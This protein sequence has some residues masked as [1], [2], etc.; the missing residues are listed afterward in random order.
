[1]STTASREN[2][3]DWCLE[4]SDDEK[5]DDPSVTDIIQLYN[6]LRDNNGILQF[7]WI[8]PGRVLP[9]DA[10]TITD[11]TDNNDDDSDE[12]NEKNGADDEIPTEFDFDSFSSEPS[13]IT[14]RR[15]PATSK[16]PRTQK[17]VATMDKILGDIYRKRKEET[18]KSKATLFESTPSST[19]VFSGLPES[20]PSS[21]HRF[22]GLPESTSSTSPLIPGLPESNNTEC[23]L[24]HAESSSHVLQGLPEST[25]SPRIFPGLPEST[26]SSRIFPL[27]PYPG[28]PSESTSS[29]QEIDD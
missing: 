10:E 29:K 27:V 24:G 21:A 28:S 26:A 22:Q 1:M 8:N 20:T 14:P 5:D 6:K 16:T 15:T 4:A 7:N 19:N 11:V 3:D 18:P 17:R 12:E 9:S 25:A 13:E 23:F 2:D